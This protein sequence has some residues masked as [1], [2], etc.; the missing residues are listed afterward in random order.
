MSITEQEIDC[1]RQALND[2]SHGDCNIVMNYVDW[3]N[4]KLPI[5]FRKI[6]SDYEYDMH[7]VPSSDELIWFASERLNFNIRTLY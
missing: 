4:N 6:I 7:K 1:Q 5:L 2:L 3:Q